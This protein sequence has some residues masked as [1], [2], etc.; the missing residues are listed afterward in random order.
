MS[1]SS[2]CLDKCSLASLTQCAN[3]LSFAG[4]TASMPIIYVGMALLGMALSRM[5]ATG[6]IRAIVMAA[7]VG[8]TAETA[9]HLSLNSMKPI[10]EGISN[11]IRGLA[12]LGV[13]GS[14]LWS[15]LFGQKEQPLTPS[16][17]QLKLVDNCKAE[18][19]EKRTRN[20]KG[21]YATTDQS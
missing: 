11:A 10:D 5:F 2:V 12:G 16:Q 14:I 1:E 9:T 18:T 3:S 6:S 15:G 20:K 17:A 8:L 21:Q 4:I 19:T 7:G 13:I